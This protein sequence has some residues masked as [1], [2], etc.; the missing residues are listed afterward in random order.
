[1]KREA[2]LKLIAWKKSIRR[3]PLILNGA[4]QVGKTWL[5]QEFGRTEFENVAYVNFDGDDLMK[6]VFAHGYDIPRIILAIQAKTHQIIAPQRT[7]IIFDEIQTCP[8]AITSLKYFCEERPDL[9]IVAAGSLLGVGLHEG[10][11]FPVGKV[12]AIDIYPM[13]FSEF[14]EAVNEGELVE[15]IRKNDWPLLTI[16]KERLIQWLR[17]YYYVGGMPE[18]V[19]AFC[20]ENAFVASRDVQLRILRDYARD[21]SKHIP[22]ADL[23]YASLVWQSLPVQLGRENKKFTFASVKK[24]LRGR[25]IQGTMQWLADAGLIHQ[26]RHVSKPNLPLAAY[27]TEGFKLFGL[28]VGLLAAQCR[29]DEKVLI[30]GS[31][32]FTEFK[33][34]LTEQYVQ[35]EL[36]SSCGITPFYW[37]AERA[38]AE[39]DFVFESGMNIV[40]LEVKAEVNLNAKSLKVYREKFSPPLSIRTSMADY[41]REDRLVNLPL[42]AIE[43]IQRLTLETA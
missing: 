38:N 19:L 11:G 41:R 9:A 32:I 4:R 2:I 21:F 18:A 26:V 17:T 43:Q 25:Q 24:G 39:I 10:T 29:L 23:P 5:M 31:R 37:S 7:L 14:L 3:K 40:P 15:A 36:R 27:A 42:Y 33:G 1:M 35:Q 12:D 34:A 22:P 8:R 6:E 13:T 20:E 28:D 16:F 30:E